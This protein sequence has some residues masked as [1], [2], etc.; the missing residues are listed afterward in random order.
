MPDF[1]LVSLNGSLVPRE[2]AQ[3]S[4][5]SVEYTYGFGVYETLRCSKG[6]LYFAEQHVARLM[7]SAQ[8]LGLNHNY[9]PLDILRM[10]EE[11][12]AKQTE[13]AYNL[14]I[15]LIGA[16]DPK[17]VLLAILPLAPSFPKQQWYRDGV[18]A[19]TVHYERLWPGAKTLNM[20]GS[21]LAYRDAKAK[22]CYDALL[23]DKDGC[24]TEGTRTNVCFIKGETIISPPTEKILEGVSRM[25]LKK[26]AA[27]EGIAFTEHD[28]PAK[29]IAECDGAIFTSTS[30]KILPIKTIDAHAFASVPPVVLRLQRAYEAFLLSSKGRM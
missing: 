16:S 20:L 6:I 12:C 22:D 7:H 9:D 30:T 27:E 23:I 29:D 13:E 2:Q 1:P 10:L 14:K 17:D 3:V 26:I 24:I 4:L 8:V 5:F 11:L 15:L 21:Y 18:S 25:I 19:I 28:V